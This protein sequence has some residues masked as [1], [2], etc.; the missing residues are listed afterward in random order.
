MAELSTAIPQKKKHFTL[1]GKTLDEKTSRQ[2]LL[3][4]SI[5]VSLERESFRNMQADELFAYASHLEEKYSGDISQ[6]QFFSEHIEY[7][8]GFYPALERAAYLFRIFDDQEEVMR[9]FEDQQAPH[10]L[11]NPLRDWMLELSLDSEKK[12]TGELILASWFIHFAVLSSLPTMKRYTVFARF[13]QSLFLRVNGLDGVGLLNMNMAILLH[14][15]SYKRVVEQF[16]FKDVSDLLNCDVNSAILLGLTIHHQALLESNV[17]LRELYQDDIEF[18]DLT[19]RQRNMVNYFFDEGFALPIPEM[20]HLNE[21]Q[22]KIMELI[23]QNHF[24]STKDLSLILRCNRKTI[25]R[26]FTELL[27]MGMV[28]QMGNGAALRYTVHIKNRPYSVL[29]KMQNVRLGEAPIQIS[30]F[31]QANN[32]K[33]TP[34]ARSNPGLF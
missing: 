8:D 21:R 23:Y 30:L 14:Q 17:Q 1:E 19:P 18:E 25:Q 32:L 12:S 2:S 9:F 27:D 29:E 4:C 31:G 15:S 24:C 5:N 7:D 11:E 13:A 33:K 16:K 28:R 26:D 6:L 22:Q 3:D 34:S 10:L 20:E